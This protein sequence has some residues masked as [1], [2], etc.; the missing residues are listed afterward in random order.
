MSYCVVMVN[1]ERRSWTWGPY[2]DESEATKQM[3]KLMLLYPNC[4]LHVSALY[5]FNDE[6]E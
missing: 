6:C 4:S 5:N 2:P 3:L 1:E